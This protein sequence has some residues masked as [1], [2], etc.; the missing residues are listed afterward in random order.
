MSR[1]HDIGSRYAEPDSSDDSVARCVKCHESHDIE[2]MHTND[3]CDFICVECQA[4]KREQQ[5]EGMER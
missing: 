2:T 1:H 4:E 5:S 3:C